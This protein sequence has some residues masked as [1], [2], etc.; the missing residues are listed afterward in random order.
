MARFSS[1][2]DSGE[3]LTPAEL[4]L[5][6]TP[7][8]DPQGKPLPYG[9]GWF[10]SHVGDRRIVWHFGYLPNE[11]SS[12]LVKEPARRLTFV[13]LANADP[14]AAPFGEGLFDGDVTASA[15]AAA[16]LRAYPEQ[17]S[18]APIPGPNWSAPKPL[19][20]ESLARLRRQHSYAYEAEARDREAIDCWR[21]G[22]PG[23]PCAATL[24][25]KGR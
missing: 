16:F 5:L 18:Q 12:L 9:I 2:L 13:V 21:R 3:L 7:P 22:E 10:V 4:E 25:A 23:R 11:A 15:L 20:D 8:L 14:L 19:F 17:T 24:S 6:Y 1:A